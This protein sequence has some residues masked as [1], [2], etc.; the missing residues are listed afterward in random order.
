MYGLLPSAVEHLSGKN[1]GTFKVT[2]SSKEMYYDLLHFSPSYSTSKETTIVPNSIV[3]G[4]VNCKVEFLKAFWEDEGSI[5]AV[6]RIMGDLKSEKV[7]KEIV[8]LHNQLGLKFNLIQYNNR[9][10][11]AIRFI[12]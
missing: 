6:G 11:F 4:D 3:N 2:F 7:I 5:S 1:I 8:K 10:F 9:G 12:F